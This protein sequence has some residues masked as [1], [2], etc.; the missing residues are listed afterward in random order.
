MSVP[1]SASP[2]VALPN[3]VAPGIRE[4]GLISPVDGTRQTWLAL[5]LGHPSPESAP[6]L[7][8]YLHGALSHQEQGMTAGIYHN[9]FGRLVKWLQRRSSVYLCPEYRGNSWMGPAAERDVVEI[10]CRARAR[11]RP[12]RTLLIGGS[13]GGTSALIFAARHPEM[14][15]G[16][17]AFCPATDPAEMFARF[18]DHFREGYGGSPEEAP[19]VYRE[20]TTRFAAERLARLP[21][22]IVHGSADAVVPIHH[23]RRLVAELRRQGACFR[24]EE[25]PGGDH[26]SPLAVEVEVEPFLDFL[27]DPAS[28]APSQ[29][30]PA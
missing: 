6:L 23:S 3:P 28:G 29:H 9:A 1:T 15:D 22:A 30:P 24:Y 11:W 13:M 19:E 18:P 26:D 16:V 21:L 2:T 12:A 14:L 27:L 20:R 7:A 10:L 8:V 25:I 4:E 5:E 17:L